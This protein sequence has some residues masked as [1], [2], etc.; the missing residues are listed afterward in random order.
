[1]RFRGFAPDQVGIRSVGQAASDGGS[2]AAANVEEA[3][4][5]AFAGK[6]F[7]VARVDVAGEQVRAIGVGARHDQRGHAHH[8]G[9][10]ARRDELLN[11][12]DRGDENF[13][14]EVP[15]L[16]RGGELIFEVHAGGASFDH[17]LHQFE[18]IQVAAESG[19]SIGD[20]RREPV[21][22][23]LAFG[24]MDLIGARECLIEFAD[25]IGHAIGGIQTLIGIHLAGVIGIGRDL[26]TAQVN[27]LQAGG[28]LLHGLIAGQG[29]QSGN[30][31]IIL[32]QLPE[33]F[34]AHARESVFDVDGAA[35]LLDVFLGVG[36]RDAFPAQVGLPVVFQVAVIA[37][38]GHGLRPL[39]WKKANCGH[40]FF[41]S[42]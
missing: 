28:D 27:R 31:E 30:V 3:L 39:R 7:A 32:Q 12:L 2:K 40:A 8:I 29:S 25:D 33:A 13:S 24:V 11:G 14:A 41:L 4:G 17:G 5:G 16:F 22:S 36:A 23:I 34:G 18:G 19:F 10:Q 9:G 37:V 42:K 15:A 6:E 35:E 1:M 21:D 20:D 38:G 26:P